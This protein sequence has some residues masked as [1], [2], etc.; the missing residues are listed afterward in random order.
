MFE[1]GK[2]Y[3]FRFNE[4]GGWTLSTLKVVG[5]DGG[6]LKLRRHGQAEFILNT[7]STS[8]HTA[9]PVDHDADEAPSPIRVVLTGQDGEKSELLI[10][11]N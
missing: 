4:D 10:G 11:G 5:V 2:S 8:F 1:I 9:D 3:T 7:A 6:L